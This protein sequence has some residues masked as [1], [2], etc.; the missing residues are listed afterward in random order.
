MQEESTQRTIA[1]VIRTGRLT[2][3]VLKRAMILYLNYKQHAPE[4]HGRISVKKLMGK[5]QGANTMEINNANIKTFNRVAARYNIDYAVQKDK[6][7]NPPKY[8]IYFK[9]RDADVIARAFRDFCDLNE[10]KKNR[11]P[12]RKKLEKVKEAIANRP[13]RERQKQK[14]KTLEASL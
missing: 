8:I 4:K 5:D 1:L 14:E 7:Q 11:E 13:E 2:E 12:L 3:I 9:G 6:S 10:K